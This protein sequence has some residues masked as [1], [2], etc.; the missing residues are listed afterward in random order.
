LEENDEDRA[1]SLLPTISDTARGPH[2]YCGA[3]GMQR[4]PQRMST[5][6]ASVGTGTL[7]TG[8]AAFGFSLSLSRED[9]GGMKPN[10]F[11]EKES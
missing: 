5:T 9:R 1:T 3:D 6:P 11:E 7:L 10:P 8:P 2:P 4:P